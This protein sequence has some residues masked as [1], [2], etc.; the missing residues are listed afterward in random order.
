VR[1]GYGYD[2]HALVDAPGKLRLGGV[3]VA[4]GM[5]LQGHSDGDVLLHAVADAILG[6]AALG[7]VGTHFPSEDEQ[8]RGAD[9]GQFVAHAL[10]LAGE[11]GYVVANLDVTVVAGRPRL[12]E[13][14]SALRGSLA[15][16]TQLDEADV[17]VK[18][19]SNDGFEATGRGEAIAAHAIVLLNEGR[20]GQVR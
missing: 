4:E 17:N 2:I 5:T 14:Q 12:A 18:L 9:S 7:D 20:P 8:L 3:E 19:K 11:L 1:V 13:Q 6:A 10:G 16:L 15:R